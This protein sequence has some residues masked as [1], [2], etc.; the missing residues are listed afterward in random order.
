MFKEDILCTFSAKYEIFDF[1]TNSDNCFFKHCFFKVHYVTF[2][3]ACKQTKNSALD[4][5]SSSL[6]ELT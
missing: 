6:Q 5:R 3:W 4:A 2:L 1:K